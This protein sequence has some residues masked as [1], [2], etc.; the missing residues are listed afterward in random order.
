MQVGSCWS[1]R[2]WATRPTPR[3][4][5]RGAGRADVIAAEDTRRLH[6]LAR[7]LGVTPGRPGRLLLRG[8][9]GPAYARAGRRPRADGARVAVVTDGGMPSVSDPGYRLVR[10]ALDA[11]L[12]VTA[13]PG[14]SARDHRAGAVRA[15]QRPV[16]LRGV[17]AAQAR[18]APGPAGR[19]G[20]RGAHAGVLRGAAPARRP[21]WP[22][23]PPRSAPDRPAAVCRE[24]TKTYEEVRRGTAGRAG[25]L[26]R[27]RRR[28]AARSPWWSA[29]A[30][31][32]AAAPAVGRPTLAAAG[33][34]S[35]WPPAW[36]ARRRSP[37]WPASTA[38]P[39][40][41]STRPSSSTRSILSRRPVR[42]A[43]EL[44]I[45]VT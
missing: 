26:G 20:R 33:A 40:G 19:A 9:R 1:A 31:A 22:T 24:L 30:P 39:S 13:A 27:R 15:A 32:G 38:C 6:R 18:R 16:L 45:S 28:R 25:R 10:A 37:P 12:P 43:C 17:P 34:P 4:A 5:A 41:R 23:A 36:T 44:R 21:P 35:R 11:G 42:S 3:P 2:R 7:D 14:P 29:G 8:Q